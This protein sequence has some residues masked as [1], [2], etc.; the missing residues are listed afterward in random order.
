MDQLMMIMLIMKVIVGCCPL[1][2]LVDIQFI[3]EQCVC[4]QFTVPQ[5]NNRR[6]IKLEDSSAA[7][8]LSAPPP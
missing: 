5:L 4:V 3:S 7:A 2:P 8:L 6:S 1:M